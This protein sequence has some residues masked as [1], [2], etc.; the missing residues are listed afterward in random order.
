M[1]V[2]GWWGWDEISSRISSSWHV[3][4]YKNA[5][6]RTKRIERAHLLTIVWA[7]SSFKSQRHLLTG[8]F[9]FLKYLFEKKTKVF[10]FFPIV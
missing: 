4:S 6:Q 5:Q 1:R 8:N 9:L 10:C 3:S 7:A 2:C